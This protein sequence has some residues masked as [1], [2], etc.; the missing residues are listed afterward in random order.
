MGVI[1][2]SQMT[3]DEVY[4]E[5]LRQVAAWQLRLPAKIPKI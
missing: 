4:E 2:T 5:F 1:D 3:P